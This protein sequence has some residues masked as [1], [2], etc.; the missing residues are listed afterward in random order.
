MPNFF[1]WEIRIK[2]ALRLNPRKM[3][4]QPKL[5]WQLGVHEGCSKSCLTLHTW[6]EN[7]LLTKIHEEA[8]ANPT[9]KWQLV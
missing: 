1:E 2:F 4:N 9:R 3:R 8:H 7:C 6:S 5:N